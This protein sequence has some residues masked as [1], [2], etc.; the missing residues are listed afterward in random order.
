MECEKSD[1][2][3]LFKVFEASKKKKCRKKREVLDDSVN[4]QATM[5][6]NSVSTSS[7]AILTL[8]RRNQTKR[9]YQRIIY[10]YVII[11]GQNKVLQM[12]R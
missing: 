5:E 6:S 2:K 11:T 9:F 4:S 1:S 12:Y 3:K 10:V 8:L 7:A